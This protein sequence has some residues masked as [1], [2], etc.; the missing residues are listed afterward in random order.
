MFPT[1]FPPPT[2]VS[3]IRRTIRRRLSSLGGCVRRPGAMA[4]VA[5]LAF[6]IRVSNPADKTQTKD[7]VRHCG[8][9]V[10]ERAK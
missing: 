6:G 2:L 8:A 4:Y 5:N 3:C 7:F 1:T 9:P 10:P